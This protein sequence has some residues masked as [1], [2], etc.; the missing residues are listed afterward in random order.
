MSIKYEILPI[1][2]AQGKGE[3]RHYARILTNSPMTSHEIEDYIQSS[4]SLTKGDVRAALSALRELML[5]KL[6]SGSRFCIPEIGYFSLAVKLNLPE[7]TPIGKVRGDHIRVRNINFRPAETLLHEICDSVHFEKE[8]SPKNTEPY[9]EESL[10]EELTEYLAANGY[11]T[12]RTMQ[13]HFAMRQYTAQRW[14]SHFTDKG[15]LKKVGTEQSPL[16]FPCE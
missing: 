7:G 8:K 2:N 15:L 13:L 1:R 12:R 11:I 9:T 14:L 16:Y 6:V 3:D 4:C 5:Q 10:W